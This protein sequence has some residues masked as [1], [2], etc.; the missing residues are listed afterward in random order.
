MKSA[1][2]IDLKIPCRSEFALIA[3][4]QAEALARRCNC[5]EEEVQDIKCAV[6]EAV[7]NAIEHGCTTSG[8]DLYYH[9]DR[10]HLVME[11]QDYGPGFDPEGL[12]EEPPEP[13]EE[14]GRGIFLMRQLMD[15]VK[16]FSKKGY[17]TRVVLARK[18]IF[19]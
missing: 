2:R 11:I 6:G 16:I 1:T 18:R 17:G 8:I 19:L 13:M 12:G 14:G 3:R 4:I 9:L 7:D 15:D 5:G 10:E